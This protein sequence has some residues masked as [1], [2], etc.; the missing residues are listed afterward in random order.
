MLT[1]QFEVAAIIK[2]HDLEM[3]KSLEFVGA[4]YEDLKGPY[5]AAKKGLKA[6]GEGLNFLSARV[7]E[8]II[9]IDNLVQHS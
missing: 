8:M 1:N 6:L 5:V 7:D 2:Q 4:E 9:K 3:E